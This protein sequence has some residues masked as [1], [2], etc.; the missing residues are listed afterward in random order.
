VLGKVVMAVI[1]AKPAANVS[2]EE[3]SGSWRRA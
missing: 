2:E 3:R 1:V